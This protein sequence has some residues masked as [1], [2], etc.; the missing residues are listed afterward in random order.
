MSLYEGAKTRVRVNSELSEELSLYWCMQSYSLEEITHDVCTICVCIYTVLY[1]SQLSQMLTSVYY[2]YVL[3]VC[4]VGAMCVLCL[5]S[6]LSVSSPRVRLM[7][8]VKSTVRRLWS[9]CSMNCNVPCYC[10]TSILPS[11]AFLLPFSPS[12]RQVPPL[13]FT[14]ILHSPSCLPISATSSP[15]Y[16]HPPNPPA[17]PRCQLLSSSWLHPP[18]SPLTSQPSCPLPNQQSCLLSRQQTL[19][20]SNQQLCA[21]SG[22]VPFV[23]FIWSPVRLVHLP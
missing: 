15:S 11:P 17:M 7:V 13:L 22:L 21:L 2:V 10:P 19:L 3:Y 6:S 18:L 12:P 8:M 9:I 5:D 20:L 16:H 4:V 14:P 1:T 23:F